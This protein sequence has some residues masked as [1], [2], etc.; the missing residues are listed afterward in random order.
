MDD[1]DKF[2]ASRVQRY[3]HRHQTWWRWFIRFFDV[4]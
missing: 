4:D 1:T 2:A 3:D